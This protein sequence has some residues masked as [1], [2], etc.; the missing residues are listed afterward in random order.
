LTLAWLLLAIVSRSLSKMRRFDMACNPPPSMVSILS[1]FPGL[2]SRAM[3]I[4]TRPFVFAVIGMS[5][6]YKERSRRTLDN[7]KPTYS[8]YLGI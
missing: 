7:G 2:G 4:T 3:G 6:D 5:R 8:G 1:G